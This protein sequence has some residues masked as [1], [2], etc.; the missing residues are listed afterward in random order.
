MRV[1]I[2]VFEEERFNDWRMAEDLFYS[3]PVPGKFKDFII[4][5][6]DSILKARHI[7]PLWLDDKNADII[8][9]M[10]QARLSAA[11]ACHTFTGDS[12]AGRIAL[13]G[14]SEEQVFLGYWQNGR[15]IVRLQVTDRPVTPYY[16]EK[17]LFEWRR[18]WNPRRK[19]YTPVERA[20]FFSSIRKKQQK[21]SD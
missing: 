10:V 11:L 2:Q 8:D 12:T 17:Y 19:N 20:R 1:V 9:T 5:N 3:L 6:S 21:G 16:Y 14:G 7:C 4:V 18:P 15:P 13:G